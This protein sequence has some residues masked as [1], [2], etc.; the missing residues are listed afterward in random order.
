MCIL[1]FK[2]FKIISIFIVMS[3]G[4]REYYMKNKPTKKIEHTAQMIPNARAK[5]PDCSLADRT[6]G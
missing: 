5:Y 1:L 4:F 6:S 2:Y 3:I